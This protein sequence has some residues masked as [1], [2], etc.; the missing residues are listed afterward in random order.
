MPAY[1]NPQ[2]EAQL[3]LT[4]DLRRRA[5]AGNRRLSLGRQAR[6][7]GGMVLRSGTRTAAS[8]PLQRSSSQ[9]TRR[10]FKGPV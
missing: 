7:A 8:A 1:P 6:Q 10:A 2:R 9:V 3:H 4:L 5:G